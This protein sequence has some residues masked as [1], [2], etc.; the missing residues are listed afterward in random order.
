MVSR[1]IKFV[2]EHKKEILVILSLGLSLKFNIIFEFQF[3][4]NITFKTLL[5]VTIGYQVVKQIA[6]VKTKKRNIK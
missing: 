5:F 1:I 6:K 4:F 3:D 2:E